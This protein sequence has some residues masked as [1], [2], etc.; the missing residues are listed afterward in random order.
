MICCL[1][2]KDEEETYFV[3]A[4]QEIRFFVVFFLNYIQKMDQWMSHFQDRA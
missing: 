2:R 3:V 1:V 4:I